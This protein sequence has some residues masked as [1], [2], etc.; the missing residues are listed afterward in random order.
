M[1]TYHAVSLADFYNAVADIS[2][3]SRRRLLWFRGHSFNH[4][5]LLP[6]LY[7]GEQYNSNNRNTYTELNLREDYRYQHFKSRVFHSIHSNPVYKNEWQEV[8]Q[9]HF[10]ETRLMDWSESAKTALSFA[11][12][13]FIDTRNNRE[14]QYKRK[15]MTPSVWILDPYKLNSILYD[16]LS[17]SKVSPELNR[18]LQQVLSEVGAGYKVP[19]FMDEMRN[20]KEIYFGND[21]KDI[22]I[23]GI[24]SLCV[25]EDHRKSVGAQLSHHVTSFEMNPFYYMILRLY[26]DAIPFEIHDYKDIILPPIAVL[27]P[28]HSERIRNQRGVFTAFPNY[29][30][31][32]KVKSYITNRKHDIRIMEEQTLIESCLYE[33]KIVAPGKLAG[34]LLASGERRGEL[35]PDVETYAN[36]IETQK[37][38][39]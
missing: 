12:E 38:Y 35:Y 22:E 15:N 33:I 31:S 36:I 8:Y 30:L 20:H 16:Y 4:Y 28:Y 13:A 23:S 9:H 3:S 37:F 34:E 21:K 5:T 19:L 18:C 26:S 1:K 11:L 27:H 14:L 6:G 25:L 7:R 17:D 24:V 2:Q 39:C 32:K 10:G 29:V